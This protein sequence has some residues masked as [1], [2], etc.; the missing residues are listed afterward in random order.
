[1]MSTSLVPIEARATNCHHEGDSR[2]TFLRNARCSVREARRLRAGGDEAA[3]G[4]DITRAVE[5][6]RASVRC[7]QRARTWRE[8]ARGGVQ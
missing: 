2:R 6:W 1:M 5:H 3:Y 8:L 7:I 4:G